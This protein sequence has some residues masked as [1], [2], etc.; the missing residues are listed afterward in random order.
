MILVLVYKIHGASLGHWWLNK[1]DQR[2]SAWLS[3]QKYTRVSDAEFIVIGATLYRRE[4]TI[5]GIQSTK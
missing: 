1:E 5:R 3:V 2:Q 4:I